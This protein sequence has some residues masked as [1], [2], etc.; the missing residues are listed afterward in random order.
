MCQPRP[1]RVATWNVEGR[2]S[3]A[4]ARLIQSLDADVLLLTEVSDR[5]ELDG[6][7]IHRTSAPMGPRRTWAAV[8]TRDP[9]RPLP[10]PHFATALV[11]SDDWT[12]ASSILPW[13]GCGPDPW[14]NGNHTDRTRR[15]LDALLSHLPRERLIWGGDWNHALSGIEYAGSAAGRAH[16]LEALEFLGLTVPTANLPHR[17]DGLLSIDHIAVPAG[18]TAATR[19]T[20]VE[21]D[22]GHR[23]L[24][25]HDA[26]L[27][28]LQA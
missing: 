8:A 16:L 24:S 26:Y 10:D 19:S 21:V 22:S 3:E 4:H 2:W 18:K 23:T 17:I 12:I 1:V 9:L 28:E 25:D 27:V 15:T 11:T 20:R 7:F 14:G 6:Y 13:K 5:L